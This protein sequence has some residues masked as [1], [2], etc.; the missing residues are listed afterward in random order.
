MFNKCVTRQFVDKYRMWPTGYQ[1]WRSTW[2]GRDLAFDSTEMRHLKMSNASMKGELQLIV[3][4]CYVLLDMEDCE[5][6]E[7]Q[8]DVE[9]KNIRQTNPTI[10][11]ILYVSSEQSSIFSQQLVHSLL[12]VLVYASGTLNTWIGFSFL[13]ITAPI[14]HLC[15]LFEVPKTVEL[16]G[17]SVC[18]DMVIHPAKVK[19]MYPHV[20]ATVPA[21][22]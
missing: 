19:Q 1:V 18:F 13:D 11:I 21:H 9:T 17:V 2:P 20:Y 3:G 15:K 7:V 12:D 10:S 14:I 5:N 16:P 22:E 8:L 6:V 4:E